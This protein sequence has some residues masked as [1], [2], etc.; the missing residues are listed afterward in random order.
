MSTFAPDIRSVALRISRAEA[1]FRFCA[2]TLLAAILLQKLALP[3]TDGGLPLNLFLFLA[4][5]LSAFVF[6]VA[7]INPSA[8]LWYALFVATGAFSMAVSPSP[9]ASGLSLGLLLLVQL[10]L[11]FRMT[12]SFPTER[13]WRL[14]ST[15]GC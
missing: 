4:A 9:R 7:E 6:E 10:P 5:A 15:V 14:V 13:L 1:A 11:V 3:G 12:S 2:G 8:L